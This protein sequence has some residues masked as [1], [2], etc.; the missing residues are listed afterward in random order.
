M[1]NS[2]PYL[3]W[4]PDTRGEN[5]FREYTILGKRAL[6]DAWTELPSSATPED[7]KEFNFFAVRV[8]MRQ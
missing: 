1:T 4:S 8:K 5:A 7:L 6:A 3:S 2:V